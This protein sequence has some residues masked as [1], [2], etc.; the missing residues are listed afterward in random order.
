VGMLSAI[1]FSCCCNLGLPVR[2][3]KPEFQ[4]P[5]SFISW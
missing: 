3:V 5:P 4:Y 2:P 1:S